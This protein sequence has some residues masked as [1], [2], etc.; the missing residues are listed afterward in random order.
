MHFDGLLLWFF[1][2]LESGVVLNGN[3]ISTEQ[4]TKLDYKHP[5]RCYLGGDIKVSFF[6]S[7]WV[8][9]S[10]WDMLVWATW[11]GRRPRLNV[12]MDWTGFKLCVKMVEFASSVKGEWQRASEW[13]RHGVVPSGQ[14]ICLGSNPFTLVWKIVRKIWISFLW[15]SYL[16]LWNLFI[17]ASSDQKTSGIDWEEASNNIHLQHKWTSIFRSL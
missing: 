5:I 11:D 4:P 10:V 15:K 1:F 12:F 7:R 3:F 14:C 9:M 17:Q 16:K 8:V 13:V 6:K 2:F